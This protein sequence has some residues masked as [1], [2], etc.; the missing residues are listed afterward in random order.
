VPSNLGIAQYLRGASFWFKGKPSEKP[1]VY[2]LST[3]CYFLSWLGLAW[4]GL[5]WLDPECADDIFLHSTALSPDYTVR[6]NTETILSMALDVLHLN[7][8]EIVKCHILY[9]MQCLNEL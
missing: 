3:C 4:L 5:A 7:K 8:R 2:Q 9:N 1:S 6:Y